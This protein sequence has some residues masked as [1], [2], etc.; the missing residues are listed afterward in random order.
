MND[1]SLTHVTQNRGKCW[2]FVKTVM[3]LRTLQNVDIF[4]LLLGYQLLKKNSITWDYAYF[5]R[6]VVC[7]GA[8][9]APSCPSFH[10]IAYPSLNV[11]MKQK[12]A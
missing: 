12:T 3:D 2:T 4:E 5:V 1:L 7:C 8:Q 10:S 6:K 9:A 11:K